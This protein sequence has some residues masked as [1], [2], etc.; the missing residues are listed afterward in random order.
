[1][2][3][4]AL[5]LKIHGLINKKERNQYFFWGKIQYLVNFALIFTFKDSYMYTL[6]YSYIETY[7]THRHAR[8][9]DH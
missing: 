9:H 8:I 6:N 5:V 7:G 2:Y 4:R 1:M 3:A